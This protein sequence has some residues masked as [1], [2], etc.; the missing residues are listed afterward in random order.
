MPDLLLQG[1]TVLTPEGMVPADVRV[2]DGRMSEVAS[3]IA[4]TR[5]EIVD[6]RGSWIGPGFVDLHAHLREPGGEWKEDIESGSEA[7]AAGGYVG[8]VAMGNTDPVTDRG[9]LARYIQDRG[10]SV[11]MVDV[12]PAGAVTE[13][14]EGERLAHLDELLAA[15]V[16][17]FSDD[18][19]SVADSGL[20]RR[21]MDYL[22]SEG[23]IV[24]QHAEDLGLSAGG[25]M[26]EGARS[27]R[28]GIE[29]IPALAEELVVARDLA[30]VRLTGARYHVQHVSSEGTVDL[31]RSA[32]AEGLPVTAE[33]TPHHLAFDDSAIE[34]VDP[35]F[36][37]YPPLRGMSDRQ[38]LRAAL[39]S[40]T[41]DA[42]ATDHAPHAAH[43][44]E[45]PF[46][47]APRGVIGLETAAAAARTFG[48][49]GPDELFDRLS[50]APAAI[51]GLENHGL[52][53]EVGN[54]AHL[55]VFA[56][57]EPFTVDGFHSR[58]QNSPFSGM[59]LSG[60]VRL[61]VFGGKPTFREGKVIR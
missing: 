54:P 12:V 39:R 40:G 42:V 46:E 45:V 8:V 24:A 55:V 16:T 61:T 36:K 26:N 7:A 1:G 34:D 25:H 14:Q 29:G 15:G 5:E 56:P 27:A 21:A 13:H 3:S 2:S 35:R 52:P 48:E 31:I 58:S 37:M 11:G 4:G 30:L 17:I 28:L 33:V 19:R 22:A 47:E 49:L 59:T 60:V 38:V 50:S 57:D 51:A 53:V 6:C 9:H 23:A 32:K 18:G 20:L 41:I 10:R 44:T 43:E